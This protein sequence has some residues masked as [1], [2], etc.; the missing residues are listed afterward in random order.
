MSKRVYPKSVQPGIPRL[1]KECPQNWQRIKFKKVFNIITN[2]AVLENEKEYNLVTVKRSRGGV[3]ARSVL[4]GKQIKTK[5][6]YWIKAGQFLIS[7]RQIVHGACGI[8]PS[9]LDGAIVSNEYL[10]LEAKE[11]FNLS[12]INYYSHT[13]YFQRT[14]FHSSIGIH[15]EKMIF[16]PD[17]WF[18]FEHHIPPLAQQQK[19]AKILS[20]WEKTIQD[21][22]ALIQEKQQL[23]KGLMQQL[24]SQQLRFLDEK[25][26]AFGDW[27]MKRLGE[28]TK[29]FDGTHQTPKY[30]QNGI[31]FYSVENVTRNNFKKTKYISIEAFRKEKKRAFLEKGDILMTRIGD[32]GTSVFVDWN[33]EASFYVSLALIKQNK[34]FIGRFLHQ[35]IGSFYF[36]KE[37][38]KRMIHLAFPKKIN[39]GE[40]SKCLVHFPP[41]PEQQKIAN[42][43]SSLDQEIQLLGQQQEQMEL[44]KRGLMQQLLTGQVRVLVE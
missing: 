6:Q 18:K 38:D 2:K 4:R 19:I 28:V 8:V 7:K 13:P 44:Q 21:T 25:G 27:K 39:L 23:K 43:L 41:L 40:I 9:S 30:V 15:V 34:A 12:Y 11:G 17:W 35:Y 31:P 32:V 37:L 5:N 33:V 36:Q 16:K 10:I 24:F 14:C 1:P 29:V 22:K 42:C 3:E 26:E 20:T